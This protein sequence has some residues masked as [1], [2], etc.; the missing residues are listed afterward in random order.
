MYPLKFGN[1]YYEKIWGGKDFNNFRDNVPEGRV[2][3]SWDIACHHN[4]ISI[5]SNGEYK[6][7]GLDELINIKGE[8]LLGTEISRESFPLLVKILNPREKLSVQVHPN[9][10]YAI[11]NEGEMGKTE[12]WYIMEAKQGASIILGTKKCSKEEFVQA[13]ENNNVEKYMNVIQVKKGDVYYVK[14]GLIHSLGSG[15]VAVEIQQNSDITY[16]VYDYDRGRELH[17]EKALEVIDFNLEGKKSKGIK[18]ENENY[19]KTYYCLNTHFALE[20]YDIRTKVLEVSDKERFYIYTC[21]EGEGTIIYNSGEEKLSLGDS[22]FIPASLGEYKIVGNLKL[23]KF[24]V[25]YIP[26]VEDEIL[27]H[28]R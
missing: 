20:L 23:L 6:G 18:I 26:K 15:I 16:R 19:E 2:G 12:A 9:D 8:D 17:I 21:V 10:E 22:I 13:I 1:L 5:V 4:G 24:Y 14:S 28:I 25:P 11:V 3:E 7:I 27:E